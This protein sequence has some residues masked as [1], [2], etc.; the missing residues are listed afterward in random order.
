MVIELVIGLLTPLVKGSLA[1]AVVAYLTTRRVLVA[2]VAGTVF[3]AATTALCGFVVFA[4]VADNGIGADLRLGGSLALL[5]FAMTGTSAAVIAY[6]NLK[7]H[8]PAM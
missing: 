1:V 4:L 7:C 2:R 6:S 8:C 5:L 3:A